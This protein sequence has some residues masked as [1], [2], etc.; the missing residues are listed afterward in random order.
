MNYNREN[1]TG[2]E[3]KINNKPIVSKKDTLCNNL[4]I[5]YKPKKKKETSDD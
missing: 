2:S 3:H 1:T 4:T 5:S